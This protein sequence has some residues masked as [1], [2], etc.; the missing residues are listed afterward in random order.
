MTTWKRHISH[1]IFSIISRRKYVI[2]F[3]YRHGYKVYK[4]CVMNMLKG[5]G[6]MRI[7]ERPDHTNVV[8]PYD[9][10]IFPSTNTA[11][12]YVIFYTYIFHSN[13]H[14]WVYKFQWLRQNH[15]NLSIF[16]FRQTSES[17]SICAAFDIEY[18][19]TVKMKMRL[20]AKYCA[21]NVKNWILSWRDYM[22][23]DMMKFWNLILFLQGTRVNERNPHI[24]AL[25][26]CRSKSKKI[27]EN[28]LFVITIYVKLWKEFNS[29]VRSDEIKWFHRV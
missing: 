8:G 2:K 12:I 13:D 20:V 7:L 10:I 4:L 27:I 6:H 15:W 9:K 3:N 11:W 16:L 21:E 22:I 29:W 18:E 23:P 25:Q 19:N 24:G 5:K 1:V 28:N 26:V 14:V 17:H